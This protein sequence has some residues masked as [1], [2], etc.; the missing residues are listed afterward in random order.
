MRGVLCVLSAAYFIPGTF[1]GLKLG[2]DQYK[3][4]L[5]KSKKIYTKEEHPYVKPRSETEKHHDAVETILIIGGAG[6]FLHFVAGFLFWPVVVP[7]LKKD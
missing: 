6:S 2:S 7:L 4:A 1:V 3:Y 5:E